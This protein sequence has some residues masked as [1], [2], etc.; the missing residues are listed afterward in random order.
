MRGTNINYTDSI[1]ADTKWELI[2]DT[3]RTGKYNNFLFW[4]HAREVRSLSNFYGVA[5]YHIKYIQKDG[6]DLPKGYV[7][8]DYKYLNE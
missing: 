5:P 8:W 7:V 3:I 4:T 6:S 2:S 1:F